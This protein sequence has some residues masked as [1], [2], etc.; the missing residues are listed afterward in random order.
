MPGIHG[1]AKRDEGTKGSFR[2]EPIGPCFSHMDTITSLKFCMNFNF[3]SSTIK[4]PSF[5]FFCTILVIMAYY[6][7]S[8]GSNRAF[9]L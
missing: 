3:D 1:V 2:P 6:M 5:R 8:Q 9:F 7:Y 4:S